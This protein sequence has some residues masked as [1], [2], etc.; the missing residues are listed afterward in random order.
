MTTSITITPESSSLSPYQ[1]GRP[2][3]PDIV[4]DDFFSSFADL[5]DVIN[6]LQHIP[7]ISTAYQALTGDTMSAGAQIAGGALFGGPIGFIASIA[8]AISEQETGKDIGSNLFATVTGK[9]Q[10]TE[11]LG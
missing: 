10:Q 4:N 5:L 2:K 9:Y 7:G 6:P 3:L 11:A 8:N 1:A